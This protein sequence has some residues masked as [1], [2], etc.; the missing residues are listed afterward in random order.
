MS[1][2][3]KPKAKASFGLPK[4]LKNEA[5]CF[6][7][8]DCRAISVL[9]FV[10]LIKL[11][12][13]EKL[14]L[15]LKTMTCK[16]TKLCSTAKLDFPFTHA[17]VGGTGLM[18]ARHGPL[19]FPGFDFQAHWISNWVVIDLYLSN[20]A[21]IK[22]SELHVDVVVQIQPRTKN[23]NFI[24]WKNGV[25]VRSTSHPYRRQSNRSDHPI[26]NRRWSSSSLRKARQGTPSSTFHFTTQVLKLIGAA[27]QWLS[28]RTV[29]RSS[30][31]IVIWSTKVKTSFWLLLEWID[32][33]PGLAVVIVGTRKD[34]QSYV[35]MKRKACAEVGIKSFDV[36]LPEQVSQAEL[37]SKVHDLNAMPDVHGLLV[38][39]CHYYWLIFR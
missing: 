24:L 9:E 12:Y 14:E 21:I 34:S 36:D 37:I 35:N 1:I 30:D 15:Q 28:V 17:W 22:D 16:N 20:S 11:I 6:P 31:T 2:N 19:T 29:A 39:I 10:W 27:H 25:R 4:I 18:M 23:T 13:K 33:V 3:T 5:F 7:V 26:W 32:Q 38:T 8:A